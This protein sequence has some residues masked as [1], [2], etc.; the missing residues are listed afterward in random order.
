MSTQ[1]LK[2]YINSRLGNSLKCELP[3]YWWKRFF[4]LV[5]ETIDESMESVDAAIEKALDRVPKA[6]ASNRCFHLTTDA[7]SEEAQKNAVLLAQVFM[8][9][10]MNAIKPVF[11][12]TGKYYGSIQSVQYKYTYPEIRLLGVYLDYYINS[13]D[14]EG[15]YDIIIADNGT[16]TFEPASY[17]QLDS[18]MS[19]TSEN[20]VSNK[21]VKAYVDMQIV[22]VAKSSYNYIDHTAQHNVCYRWVNGI[23]NVLNLYK[24][25]QA[26]SKIAF[27]SIIEFTTPTDAD[28]VVYLR[29]DLKW[30]NGIE[31]TWARDTFY[32]L[33][34]ENDIVTVKSTAS[35]SSGLTLSDIEEIDT[36]YL[37][38]IAMEDSMIVSCTKA[39]EYAI[40]QGDWVAIAANVSTPEIYAGQSISFRANLVSYVYAKDE[41]KFTVNK[42]FYACGSVMSMLR[43]TDGTIPTSLWS[44]GLED[45]YEP[46]LKEMFKNTPIV[47]CSDNLLPATVLSE[48]A[49]RSMFLNCKSLIK[50]PALPATSLAVRDL[51]SSANI[52]EQGSVYQGMFSGCSSLKVAPKL[53]ATTLTGDCYAEMFM[54][55]TSLI[56][57]PELPA[58]LLKKNCYTGMFNG[59][60]SLTK[61][62]A[63]P[64]TS[65]AAGCYG[66]NSSTYGSGMFAYCTSL[67]Y[68]PILA[69]KTLVS[70]CYKEMFKG[71]SNLKYV[72]MTATYVSVG[73]S[74]WLVGVASSGTFI[75][76]AGVTLSE[77][78]SGIPSGWTVEEVAV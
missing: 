13:T 46:N 41:G 50:A 44:S 38:F 11:V 77:G 55:C 63:L 69:A 54:D 40:D 47:G 26:D 37:T 35:S 49:Y 76:A 16:C 62:P 28:F 45:N 48:N 43:L 64:A 72:K 31:P 25:W 57:A 65:L 39:M 17:I 30:Q 61:A 9:Y 58:T 71:C 66:K 21:V 60:S 68:A 24:Y 34:I 67:R 20:A 2:E 70:N 14:Y 33:C 10:A 4:S 19:N 73:L 8:E 59:C 78:A 51:S 23:N 15:Y 22:E 52:I 42:K 75:K 56:S 7:S 1:E 29:N 74:D 32:Q 6:D 53:P 5:A 18:Q 12:D 3:S 27:R 36:E